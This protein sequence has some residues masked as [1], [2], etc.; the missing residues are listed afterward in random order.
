MRV[1]GLRKELT[2]LKLMGLQRRAAAAGVTDDQLEAALDS[3]NPKAALIELL[4]SMLPPPMRVGGL[5]PETG[6]AAAKG[7]SKVDAGISSG[8]R[9]HFGTGAGAGPAVAHAGGVGKQRTRRSTKHVMLSYQ[10]CAKP[11]PARACCCSSALH[12]F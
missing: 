9:P 10:W 6:S 5:V 11:P 3:D 2:A 12:R 8:S 1:E 4:V 7:K